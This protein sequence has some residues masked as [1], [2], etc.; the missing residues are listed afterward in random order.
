MSPISCDQARAWMSDF[1]AGEILGEE[2][3]ALESHQEACAAC[4]DEFDRLLLQDRAIAELV[5]ESLSASLKERVR[6]G[7]ARARTPRRAGLIAAAACLVLAIGAWLLWPAGEAPAVAT[8]ERVHGEVF[9]TSDG[10]AE[11]ASPAST[12]SAGQG[13]TTRGALSHAVVRFSDGT[14]VALGGETTIDRLDETETGKLVRVARG[15]VQAEVAKQP[16]GRPMVLSSPHARATV[17]GTRLRL[18]V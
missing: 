15:R 8:V 6:T 4:R 9:I 11:P 5:G 3:K 18:A 1:I 13:M 14:E 7:L 12:L 2:Q 17:L 16:P 10:S